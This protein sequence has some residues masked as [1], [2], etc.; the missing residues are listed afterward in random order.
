MP[1]SFR[2]HSETQR[3]EMLPSAGVRK[4]RPRNV[5]KPH[6][7]KESVDQMTDAEVLIL[8][9]IKSDI[10]KRS[11]DASAEKEENEASTFAAH[12]PPSPESSSGS[13]SEG[14]DEKTKTGG[15]VL[16]KSRKR[17]S[18]SKKRTCDCDGCMQDDC[19]ACKYCLD[20]PRNN[21]P[22]RLRKRCEKRICLKFGPK[23]KTPK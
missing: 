12:A 22:D 19:N 11:S 14:G 7:I 4:G 6:I 5:L 10:D 8:A 21:G 1:P 17:T 20:H 23:I 16:R 15:R 13:W 9:S 18:A 2:D 3:T